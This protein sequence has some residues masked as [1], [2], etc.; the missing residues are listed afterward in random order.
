MDHRAAPSAMT[1]P[2][3]VSHLMADNLAADRLGHSVI[4]RR[5]LISGLSGCVFALTRGAEAQ[6]E[7]VWRIGYLPPASE[8]VRATLVEALRE[9]GYIEGRT[10][11]FD[12]GAAE[13]DLERL[14]ELA[15]RLVHAKDDLIVAV[16]PPAIRAA[17][18]AT[19]TIPVVMAFWGG[20]DL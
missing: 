14:P 16:S 12:V 15:A 4:T 17:S 6:A 2:Q 7:K 18:Q 20:L 11:G 19:R 5:V 9:L 3:A 1:S 10:A 13:N 8:F